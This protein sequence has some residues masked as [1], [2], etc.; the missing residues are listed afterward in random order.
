MGAVEDSQYQTTATGA[1]VDVLGYSCR[2]GAPPTALP[3]SVC[4]NKLCRA[5]CLDAMHS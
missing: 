5:P 3:A 4:R 1:S 2:R